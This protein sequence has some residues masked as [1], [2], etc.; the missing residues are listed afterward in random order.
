MVHT[1]KRQ[2]S[3]VPPLVLTCNMAEWFIQQKAG[4]V[5][6]LQWFFHVIWH[7]ASYS[8]EAN[9]VKC[10]HWFTICNTAERFIQQRHGMV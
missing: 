4:M 9:I 2:Y 7:I 8:K 10:L 5:Q 1:A 3:L 6:C